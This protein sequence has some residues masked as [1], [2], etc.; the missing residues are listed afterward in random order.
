M[1][2]LLCWE[3]VKVC[4]LLQRRLIVKTLIVAKK[5]RGIWRVYMAVGA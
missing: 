2:S 5:A 3:I 4:V 1:A